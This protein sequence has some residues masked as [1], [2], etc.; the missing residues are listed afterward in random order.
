MLVV[1]NTESLLYKETHKYRTQQTDCSKCFLCPE[2]LIS[3]VSLC[4]YLCTVAHVQSPACLS[5]YTTAMPIVLKK[6]MRT[7][8]MSSSPNRTD[9]A[10]TCTNLFCVSV[11]QLII[12]VS[13]VIGHWWSWSMSIA[14]SVPVRGV[15][16]K[17]HS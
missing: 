5:F 10:L 15:S 8:V 14:T 11:A 17:L 2:I 4:R 12:N 6:H 7:T 3:H 13:R 9:T 16:F 1:K